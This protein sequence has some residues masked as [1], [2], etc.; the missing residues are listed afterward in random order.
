[1]FSQAPAAVNDGRYA[2]S[3]IA[4]QQFSMLSFGPSSGGRAQ[5]AA[6]DP[7]PAG[8]YGAEPSGC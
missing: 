8:E 5:P 3:P 1:M 7:E 4:P 6:A 2:A